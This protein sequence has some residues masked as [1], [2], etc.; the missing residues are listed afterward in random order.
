M[1]SA[2]VMATATITR[3][4]V[5]RL[6]A[7][8]LWIYASDVIDRDG[9]EAGDIVA[10]RDAANQ[11]HGY[12]FFSA[13]SQI[14]LRWCAPPGPPPDRAFWRWRLQ[15]AEAY[16][17]LVVRETEAYRLVYSDGDLLSSLL[18][19]RYGG[20]V[21][22]QTLSQGTDRLKGL[23]VDLLRELYDPQS[24]SERNDAAVRQHEALPLQKGV[25]AGELPDEIAIHMHGLEFGV[26]VLGGQ[27]TGAFLDQREN[28][29]AAAAYARGR[30]L[31]AFTFAG[32]FALH[33]APQ[34]D[35]VT[36][37][38]ISDEACALARRN[39]RRN[40]VSN[41]TVVT[42]NVFDYLRELERTED[43]FDTIVL[44][45]PAFVKG[46]AAL[47]GAYRGYK[48][49][50]LRALRL[51][52]PH[53]ILVT[54]SCSYHLPEALFLQVLAEA[55]ADVGRPVRVIERRMQARDHPYLP[56]VPETWYLK[57]LIAQVLT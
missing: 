27:K 23:W 8:H 43:R 20:H 32:G 48:E 52:R 36:A 35:A 5:Q 2:D 29:A 31:D 33:L 25:L 34:A 16:R 10:L 15:Q 17:R 42:A 13:T 51:L 7:G 30:V 1:E 53:G 22:L 45:P 38:D 57:C 50:N 4:A 24:I 37:V 56:G 11:A 14:T 9:A 47:A 39:A 26:A 21:V 12:A 3:K 6:K 44:D 40:R 55:A 49:I 18:V 19:D 46:K 28:Y 41:L 54:C